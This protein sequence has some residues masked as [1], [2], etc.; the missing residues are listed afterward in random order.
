MAGEWIKFELATAT[1]PE[2]FRIAR[3]VGIDPDAVVG[4]LLRL[5]AWFDTNSV[6]GVV[7]GVVDA[8]V[9]SMC[10]CDGFVRAL[11]TVGWLEVDMVGE[12]ISLPNF[13]R[14]NGE[15]AKK[16][17]LKNRRQANWRDSVDANVDTQASTNASTREEKNKNKEDT[18]VAP[19]GAS[20]RP[21]GEKLGLADFLTA[22]RDAGED[23]IP[24]SDAVFAYADRIGLPRDF[25]AL[26]WRWFKARYAA[27][28]QAGVKGW[29][30]TFRNAVEGNWPKYWFQADDK[31]WQ[32]TTAGKQAKLDAEASP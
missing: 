10:H 1:K 31:S 16:R 3:I 32:L 24:E 12:K 13:D 9:D 21:K 29:R 5:W 8:D 22:C 20:S 4:K 17:A 7:D 18:P 11:V 27:K 2:V 19:K 28:R 26:A 6:D 25:V 30:Q 23:A 14:H 15:T